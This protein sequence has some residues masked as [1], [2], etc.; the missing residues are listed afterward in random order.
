[1][2]FAPISYVVSA[3]FWLGIAVLIWLAMRSRLR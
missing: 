1:M 3:L 2:D